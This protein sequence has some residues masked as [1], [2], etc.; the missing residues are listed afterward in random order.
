MQRAIQQSSVLKS[1]R[2]SERFDQARMYRFRVGG[3]FAIHILALDGVYTFE[4]ERR[5]QALNSMA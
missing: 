4:G 3:K 2:T 1:R 5:Q